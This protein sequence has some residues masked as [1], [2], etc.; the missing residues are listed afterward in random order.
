M[1]L[2]ANGPAGREWAQ[3]HPEEVAKTEEE[4]GRRFD[5][6]NER[7]RLK[8]PIMAQLPYLGPGFKATYE[9]SKSDPNNPEAISVVISTYTADGRTKAL[10]WINGNGWDPATLDIVWTTTG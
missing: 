3:S 8:Y 2:Y 9:Q 4:A 7:L 5:E 10:D 1:Y 6:I